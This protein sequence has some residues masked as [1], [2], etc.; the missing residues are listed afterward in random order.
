MSDEPINQPNEVYAQNGAAEVDPPAAATATAPDELA[1]A[2][3]QAEEYRTLLQRERADFINYRRRMEAERAAQLVQ[4]RL[5]AGLP[6]LDIVDDLERAIKE[7]PA[8]LAE[9]QWV[10]GVLLIANKLAGALTAAGFE[11][12]ES[13]GKPF[14]PRLHESLFEHPHAEIPAGHISTVIRNG[15]KMG[16]RVVRAAQVGVSQGSGD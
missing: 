3:Q 15:Y 5:E 2:R 1:E 16:D 8:D 10:K 6:L 13:L 12:I 4:G 7:V 14:D 9:N 11:R